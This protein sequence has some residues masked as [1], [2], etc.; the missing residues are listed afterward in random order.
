MKVMLIAIQGLVDKLVTAS[1]AEGRRS[2]YE[3]QL[4]EY[5]LLLQVNIQLLSAA[6]VFIKKKVSGIR[7]R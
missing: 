6:L 1:Q 5:Y 7:L 4:Y 3:V 2:I